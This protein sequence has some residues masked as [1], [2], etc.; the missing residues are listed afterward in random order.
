MIMHVENSD[1]IE[2]KRSFLGGKTQRFSLTFTL[3]CEHFNPEPEYIQ[4]VEDQPASG[5]VKIVKRTLQQGKAFN[6][7]VGV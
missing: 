5:R 7:V 4:Y 1:K 6:A 3:N 2:K